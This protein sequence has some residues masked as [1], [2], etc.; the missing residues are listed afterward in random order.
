MSLREEL[1]TN[2]FERNPTDKQAPDY[3]GSLNLR[4]IERRVVNGRYVT[5]RDF[6]QDIVRIAMY[7]ARY[8]ID[9][10]EYDSSSV[11][12]LLHNGTASSSKC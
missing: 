11:P 12:R 5:V 1:D 3:D 7:F 8:W 9:I 2:A 10:M 4:K 6:Y